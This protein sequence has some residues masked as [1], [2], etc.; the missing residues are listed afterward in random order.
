M[1]RGVYF[2]YRKRS[3]RTSMRELEAEEWEEAV[4]E[5]LG[6]GCS[7]QEGSKLPSGLERVLWL[8]G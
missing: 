7:Q 2:K 6:H 1:D 8:S 3:E 4:C 5:K